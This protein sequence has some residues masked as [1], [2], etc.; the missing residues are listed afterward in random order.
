MGGLWGVLM[1]ELIRVVMRV[2]KMRGDGGP[3][4]MDLDEGVEDGVGPVSQ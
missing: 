2:W 4:M 3:L 1:R